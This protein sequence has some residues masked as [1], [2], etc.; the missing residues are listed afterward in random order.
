M[1]FCRTDTEQPHS[2]YK[3]RGGAVSPGTWRGC[4]TQGGTARDRFLPTVPLCHGITV[5]LLHQF[6]VRNPPG[7]ERN[8]M[9]H[10]AASWPCPTSSDHIPRLEKGAASSWGGRS[11]PRQPL[12]SRQRCLASASPISQQTC[13]LAHFFWRISWCRARCEDL[14]AAQLYGTKSWFCFPWLP[15]TFENCKRFVPK[16]QQSSALRWALKQTA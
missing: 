13:G 6:T 8:A 15:C 16:L 3:G 14:R 5:D 12:C 2:A 11:S 1:A 7:L 10:W 4:R 9:N